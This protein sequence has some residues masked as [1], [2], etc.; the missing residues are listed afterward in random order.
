M[1]HSMLQS[2]Q[3]LLSGYLYQGPER[4]LSTTCNR[5]RPVTLQGLMMHPSWNS[6]LPLRGRL[7]VA[8]AGPGGGISACSELQC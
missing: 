5:P 2:L 7:P 4:V 3:G 8:A 6:V 1:H